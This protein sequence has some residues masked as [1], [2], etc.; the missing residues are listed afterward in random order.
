MYRVV[1][2]VCTILLFAAAVFAQAPDRKS[3][4]G[5]GGGSYI[6]FG[7]V[8]VDDGGEQGTK[9]LMYEIILN[10]IGDLP[11]ARQYVSSGGRYQFINLAP[12]PYILVVL[13]DHEEI[14]RLRVEI[15]SGGAERVR[16]NIEL[17]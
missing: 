15:S 13:L 5:I 6:L 4:L 8:T 12:G 7:D 17:A 9:P 1:F 2:S 10:N 14:A 3:Q 16:Q 11:A